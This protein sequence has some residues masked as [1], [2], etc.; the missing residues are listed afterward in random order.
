MEKIKDD[1]LRA[2]REL[3]DEPIMTNWLRQNGKEPFPFKMAENIK[4]NM[5]DIQFIL[6]ETIKKLNLIS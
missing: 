6:Q 3:H 1:K 4:L 2:Q 5:N